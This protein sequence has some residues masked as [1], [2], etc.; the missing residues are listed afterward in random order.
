MLTAVVNK[1][2]ALLLVIS[3]GTTLGYWSFSHRQSQGHST[4]VHPPVHEFAAGIALHR[5]RNHHSNADLLLRVSFHSRDLLGVEVRGEVLVE[6]LSFTH[7]FEL[8]CIKSGEYRNEKISN[9][10]EDQ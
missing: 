4:Q 2:S 5:K 8:R 9:G 7:G 1:N 6:Y 10:E 3:F